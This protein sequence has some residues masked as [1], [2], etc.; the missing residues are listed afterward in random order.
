MIKTTSNKQPLAIKIRGDHLH[1]KQE[2]ILLL[3][4]EK[5]ITC[6]RRC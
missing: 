6:K 2:L 3:Y 1:T 5:T 4:V